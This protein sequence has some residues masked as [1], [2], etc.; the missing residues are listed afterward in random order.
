MEDTVSDF[1]NLPQSPE[2]AGTPEKPPAARA[3]LT[4]TMLF[5]LREASPWLRFI[6]ILGF[7][8][9][10]LM[11][12][13]G[14]ITAII[15]FAVSGFADEFDDFPMGIIGLVY[16]VLAVVTF[17]PVRF[18]YSFGTRIRNYQ[19]NNSEQELEQA[20]KNNKSLWKFTGILCIIYLAFIPLGIVF[21]VVKALNSVFM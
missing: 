11:F 19:L 17:F 12:L 3:V 4:D 18:T 14:I 2:N 9:C 5:Y 1:E 8:G 13:G 21:A 15:L 7:I 16:S 10:A 6:G 20:F